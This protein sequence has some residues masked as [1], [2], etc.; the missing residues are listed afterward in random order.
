MKKCVR[1]IKRNNFMSFDEHKM[2]NI[3]NKRKWRHAEFEEKEGKK[4]KDR[5][6]EGIEERTDFYRK[7]NERLIV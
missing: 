3:D 7:K 4:K 1:V 5:K 6:N 2:K